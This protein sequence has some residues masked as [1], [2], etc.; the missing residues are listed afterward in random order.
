M[1]RIVKATAGRRAVLPLAVIVLLV[2]FKSLAGAQPL[3][4]D[5]ASA[6]SF[7]G[8]VVAYAKRSSG[9]PS[10]LLPSGTNQSLVQLEPTLATVSCE[11]IKQ[12]LLRE[13]GAADPW[14]GTIYLVLHPARTANDNI[15]VT[16]QKF[17]NGWQYQVDLP[18]QVDRFRYVRAMVQVLLMEQANRTAHA[19]AAE[20]PLWLI[21]GFAQ[22]LLASNEADLI[23]APPHG[24]ANGLS[25]SST[26]HN[27]RIETLPQQAQKKL[28]GRPPL[29]FEEL[30]WPTEQETSGH[31]SDLY[32]GSALLFVGE[33]LRISDGRASLRAMLAQL[34]QHRNW[35]F[36]FLRA[37]HE[38][39]ERPLDVEKWWALSL[40]ESHGRT[41]AQSWSLEESRQKLDEALLSAVQVRTGANELPLHAE[42][43]LQTVIREWDPARQTQ[44]L[45]AALRELGLLRLRVAHE[46]AGLAHDY[47]LAIGTYLQQRNRAGSILS[48]KRAGQRRAVEAAVRQLDALDALRIALRP[49]PK[50]AAAS[51]SPAPPAPAP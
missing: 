11:R 15:T 44:A 34:P 46:Y 18:D 38:H 42:V 1:N 17:K 16:S 20:V 2:G 13:L 6:R 49:A 28:H 51:P 7:S 43:S 40:A 10:G 33:L 23:L 47:S 25:F 4:P 39:F 48:T 35:Q 37:F 27:S 32:G 29:S 50:P 41:Q 14:R 9:P 19:G 36:A 3:N 22:L 8:Q 31:A 26:L 24:I 5:L 21:E 45:D 12:M 30:S